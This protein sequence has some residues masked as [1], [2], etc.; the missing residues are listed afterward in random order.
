[1]VSLYPPEEE[2]KV[3]LCEPHPRENAQTT[4]HSVQAL[5]EEELDHVISE[6]KQER[7][8]CNHNDFVSHIP[9]ETE[10]KENDKIEGNEN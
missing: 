6:G 7:E 2:D 9:R 5:E 1:V 10:S 3:C 8:P 4:V